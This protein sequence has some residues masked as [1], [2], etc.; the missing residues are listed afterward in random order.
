[1]S[2]HPEQD[3][4][5]PELEEVAR[6]LD[7]AAA[8]EEL[9]RQEAEALEAA[10][11]LDRTE[12]TL[13]AA[14]SG[15]DRPAR[16]RSAM[17]WVG[18]LVAAAAVVVFLLTRAHDDSKSKGPRGDYLGDPTFA[19]VVPAERAKAW[20]RIEWTGPAGATYRVRV[21]DAND[22]KVIHGPIVRSASTV[23]PLSPEDTAGWPKKVVIEIEKQLADGTWI[24]AEPR[25]SELEP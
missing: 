14:W 16:R 25:V 11:G 10:P 6:L 8:Q 23:L 1:M 18:L 17:G 4:E 20:D 2:E 21:R 13:T 22:G 7:Q 12:A 24:P 5:L 15:R 9:E 19:V 3:P